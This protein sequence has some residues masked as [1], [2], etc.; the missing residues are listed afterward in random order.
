MAQITSELW[1][2]LWRTKNTR[3]EYKFDINGTEYGPEQEV[4]H[5][6]D[7]GLWEEFG[8]G[9]AACAKLTLSLFA[10]NIP[11]AAKIK[12]FIRL[13]N[14]KQASEWLP[15]GVY[16]INR[17]SVEDGCWTVEAFDVMRKAEN[18]WEPDQSIE[19]PMPM[20]DAVDE[21]C[22]I[23]DCELDPRTV[24]NSA[25][26]IDYPAS[27]PESETGDYYSIRQELQW[28]AAAHGG[29]WI[30]TGEGKLL[31]V[32]LGSEPEETYY[33]VSEYG[34]AITFGGVRI[35]V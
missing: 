35:L 34:D 10:E 22:R 25:Y 3:R 16:F 18:A 17:R 11:R 26:T 13:V 21:F 29:N 1:K 30:V 12:R 19:F 31:L 15:A 4:S 24:L 28:I 20:P 9:N 23:M 32:P 6:V 2:T 33:L 8:I 27:D 7:N 5:S 14:G